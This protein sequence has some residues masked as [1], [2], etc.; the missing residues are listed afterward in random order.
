MVT[1]ILATN[2][3]NAAEGEARVAAESE[4][5]AMDRVKRMENSE[6]GL[7]VRTATLQQ[8]ASRLA[9]E[10]RAAR[11]E[12]E[13][14]KRAEQVGFCFHWCKLAICRV[15]RASSLVAPW[16]ISVAGC[17]CRA[18]ATTR[19]VALNR[20]FANGPEFRARRMLLQSSK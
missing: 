18:R 11:D 17:C 20:R 14:A 9:A 15:R 4:R 8:E 6:A 16:P 10:L 12:C 19:R 13:A 7:E 2:R 3:C 5:V 1:V